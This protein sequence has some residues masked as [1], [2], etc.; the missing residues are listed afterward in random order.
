MRAW[1]TK[2][3]ALGKVMFAIL[4]VVL[5]IVAALIAATVVVAIVN[6][7]YGAENSKRRSKPQSAKS[8]NDEPRIRLIANTS[9]CLESVAEARIFFI[10][11]FKNPGAAGKVYVM[12]L[13]RYSDG[14]TNDSVVDLLEG[15]VPGHLSGKPGEIRQLRATFDF[16]AEEHRLLECRVGIGGSETAA[17]DAAYDNPIQITAID[18]ET[19]QTISKP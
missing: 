6:P 16:N 15:N 13:R 17:S 3:S 5:A 19:F 9:S 8:A 10:L 12:P 7:D 14:T 4:G 11:N 1:W 2:R 18:A